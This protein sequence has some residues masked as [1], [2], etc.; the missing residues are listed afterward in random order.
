VYKGG[1]GEP[2]IVYKS[3]HYLLEPGDVVVVETGGGGGYGPPG[4]RDEAAIAR[5]LLYGYIT[6]AAAERDY[7]YRSAS[8][9]APTSPAAG[10]RA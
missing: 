10:G 9:S 2:E 7:G 4:E 8:P 1:T 3:E 5:D 6:P